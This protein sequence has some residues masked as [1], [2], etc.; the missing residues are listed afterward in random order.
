MRN[1]RPPS[2]SRLILNWMLIISTWLWWVVKIWL[3]PLWSWI[4]ASCFFPVELLLRPWWYS[5]QRLFQVLQALCWGG[6]WACR[7]THEISESSWR[8]SCA[9]CHQP[10]SSSR[11]GHSIGRNWI[12][13]Q[14]GKKSQSGIKKIFNRN[15]FNIQAYYNCIFHLIV[16]ARFAQGG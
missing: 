2:T 16:T 6:T 10:S 3:L 7:E 14:S 9:D 5:P 8:K 1:L 15:S 11:M 4:V 13:S 12:C